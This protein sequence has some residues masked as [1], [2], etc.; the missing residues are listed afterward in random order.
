MD[1]PRL[2]FGVMTRLPRS[3]GG[4]GQSV[5]DEKKTADGQGLTDEQQKQVTKLKEID[6]K[7]RQHEQ[8]HQAAGSG[9]TGSASY[10]YQEGPDGKRYAVGGEVP[11][12]TGSE[13]TPEATIRK[14]E[15]V[16]RAA[17]APADPSPQDLRV[18]AQAEMQKVRAQQELSA[19]A[20]DEHAGWGEAA[21]DG[22]AAALPMRMARGAAAYGA[23]AQLGSA[24]KPVTAVVT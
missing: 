9:H 24:T 1:I 16:K 19:Q 8:A 22:S 13:R 21:S 6:A 17:L 11:I 7:V 15:A 20:V 14:M 2:T 5:P 23:A 10:S 18:A 3:G 4:Q 12:D